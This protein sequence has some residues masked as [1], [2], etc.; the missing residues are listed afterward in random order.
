MR[1]LKTIF[2]FS[3]IVIALAILFLLWDTRSSAIPGVYHASGVWGSST[4]MLR[5]D[6]TVTQ[7]LNLVNQYKQEAAQPRVISGRWEEHGRILFDQKI[8]IK[9]F[10]GFGAA[11][12]GKVYDAY[13]ASY[14]PVALS[15]LGIEIDI[16]QGIVYRK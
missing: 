15:G 13:P 9:P 6:H 7:E 4:L 1:Q 8:V 14:G 11:D 2:I 10:I 16:S 12:N 3:L 5:N